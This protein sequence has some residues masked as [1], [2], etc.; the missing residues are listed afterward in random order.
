M[1]C[2]SMDKNLDRHTLDMSPLLHL[3]EDQSSMKSNRNPPQG[4]ATFVA[5]SLVC[6]LKNLPDFEADGLP[7]MVLFLKMSES[8][9]VR[10]F[11]KAHLEDERFTKK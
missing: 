10:E 2:Y 9:N 8:R 11:C 4:N 7:V 6:S 5:L 3:H 1:L